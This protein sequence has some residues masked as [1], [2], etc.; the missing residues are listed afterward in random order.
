LDAATMAIHGQPH[1]PRLLS[2][3]I[4]QQPSGVIKAIDL[5]PELLTGLHDSMQEAV[6]APDG[7]AKRAK[8]DS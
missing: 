5:E 4:K 2:D 8:S 3:E 1:P 7:R 6:R